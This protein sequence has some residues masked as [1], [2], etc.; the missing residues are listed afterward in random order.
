MIVRVMTPEQYAQ[1]Q[2]RVQSQRSRIRQ[3][4]SLPRVIGN[5]AAVV[6]TGQRSGPPATPP[7][8][9]LRPAVPAAPFRPTADHSLPTASG[10]ALVL[11]WPPSGNTAVRHA[12]GAHY[13]KPE[14]AQYRRHVAALCRNLAPVTGR[15]ILHVHLSPPDARTRDADNSI[16]VLVD[17]LV[18]CGYL[19]DDSLTYM[20]ELHVTTDDARN[21][22][23][24]V[25]V[26]ALDPQ[27][28]AA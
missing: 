22:A 4:E 14:V 1:H 13:I 18:R 5:D 23:A 2:A 20:R 25:R 24:I 19:I 12:N 10:R 21:A 3:D 16:K 27:K 9:S 8:G 15:Y 26:E 7:T 11:P 28:G 17:A 6:D